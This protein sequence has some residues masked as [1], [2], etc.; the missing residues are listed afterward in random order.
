MG[1]SGG[2]TLFLVLSLTGRTVGCWA[3]WPSGLPFVFVKKCGAFYLFRTAPGFLLKCD[4]HGG[5]FSEG[6]MK[7]KQFLPASRRKEERESGPDQ[8][9]TFQS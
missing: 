8:V 3:P 9:K 4:R 2:P 7:R 6:R 5:N 1:G